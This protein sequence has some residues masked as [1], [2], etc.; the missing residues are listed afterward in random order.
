M[1]FYPPFHLCRVWGGVS[2]PS[3]ICRVIGG[4]TNGLVPVHVVDHLASQSAGRQRR[5][6][7]FERLILVLF[8]LG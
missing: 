2:G 4:L 3:K 7:L 1:E 8:P 5:Y 6:V